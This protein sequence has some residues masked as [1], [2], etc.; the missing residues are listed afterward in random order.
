MTKYREGSEGAA[1]RKMIDR[2]KIAMAIA[3][4]L[5]LILLWTVPLLKAEAAQTGGFLKFLSWVAFAV[6]FTVIYFEEK[7]TDATES[8]NLFYVGWFVCFGLG[9]FLR[10]CGGV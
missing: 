3:T 8:S 5:V 1:D 7:I 2:F 9:F 6:S 4:A 10:I